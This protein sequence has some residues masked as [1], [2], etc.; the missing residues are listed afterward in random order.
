MAKNIAVRITNFFKP[1][2]LVTGVALLSASCLGP[3]GGTAGGGVMRTDNGGRDW[4][5]SNTVEVVTPATEKQDEKV[6]TNDSL[7]DAAVNSLIFL[8]GKAGSL[9]AATS[10]GAYVSTTDGETW[11]QYLKDFSA[12]RA[13]A[14][15]SKTWL[16]SGFDAND[17]GRILKTED[18]GSTWQSILSLPAVRQSIVSLAVSPRAQEDMAALS[19]TGILFRS[20]DGGKTWQTAKDFEDTGLDV[21]WTGAGLF[22]LTSSQG[23]FLQRSS[24]GN[25]ENLTE[26]ISSSSSNPFEFLGDEDLVQIS[27]LFAFKAHPNVTENIFI[28]TDRGLWLSRNGGSSWQHL[29]LPID[30]LQGNIQ[31]R[32]VAFGSS[33][34][35][36]VAGLDNVLYRS[37]NSGNSWEVESIATEG[38]IQYILLNTV[39]PALGWLG[40]NEQ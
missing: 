17:I 21:Q 25:F 30:D 26:K 4:Q 3:I 14:L 5:A 37:D 24:E 32:A 39:I 31:I 18:G 7:K 10:Q 2:V 34:N 13:L 27:T 8:P 35:N 23:L 29:G 12:N 9:L 22:V 1:L 38:K 20:Q 40:I 16:L 15:D 11:R 6:E 28:S 19:S 33:P 36:L